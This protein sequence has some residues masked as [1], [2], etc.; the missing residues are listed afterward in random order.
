MISCILKLILFS[1]ILGQ[2]TLIYNNNCDRL[3]KNTNNG[4]IVLIGTNFRSLAELT[5]K[6]STNYR[7]ENK[8]LKEY[9]NT[10]H[11]KYKK[12]K[13]P[14]NDV[15]SKQNVYEVPK[16]E[17]ARTPNS[18]IY[19][20][21][22]Y[23]KEKEAKSNRSSNSIKYLKTQNKHYN[24][25]YEKPEINFEKFTDKSNNK[26]RECKNKKKSSDKL[27]SSSKDHDKNLINLETACVECTY[28]CTIPTTF[29]LGSGI[30]AGIA[31]AKT[32]IVKEIT[33]TVIVAALKALGVKLFF[34]SSIKSV[35]ATLSASATN[36]AA[37][38]A[39][40]AWTGF[41]PYAIAALNMSDIILQLYINCIL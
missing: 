38:I 6:L 13:Y 10:N 16:N 35:A 21:E 33:D 22:K 12:D 39:S 3:Y 23:N 26:S 37:S 20:K 17:N 9:R 15:K 30:G 32:F 29:I 1:I 31:A 4:N 8:E 34:E 36:S 25:F 7:Q 14:K 41:I 28:M 27:S 24:N 18:K 11:T 19:T 2:L 40:A 5:H